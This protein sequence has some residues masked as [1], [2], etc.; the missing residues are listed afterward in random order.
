MYADFTDYQGTYCGTLITTQ[1]QWMPAVREAC[2][3]LDSIT[4]GRL[5]CGAPVDDTVK[6]AACALAD[7]AARYQAAK[8]DERSRPGLAS[9]NTDGYSETLNTVRP[10]RT[11]HG[12][13]AGGRGYLPAAQPSAALCG[14]GW[15]VRPLYVC[16][17]TVTLTHLH[18]DG[19]ADRD[20]KEETTLT[21][22]SWYGQ[23]KTAVDSTGLHAAR[24]YKCRIPE[25]AA[26]AG[27]DIAPGDKITCGTVTATVL[28][29][30]DNRG[31]PAP[32]WYVEAS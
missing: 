31:H 3:Y 21:G 2:A 9:F 11:V 18:Y 20:V 15:E 12:R 19:D 23:A 8:A 4:F 5:K 17:Q 32:H 25:S 22:V 24:V 14:P 16:D 6:L 10:D 13:H 26:P 28:D 27:L 7:V 29:V 30:H 1:G